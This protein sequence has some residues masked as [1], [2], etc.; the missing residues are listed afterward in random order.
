[1]VNTVSMAGLMA[2][3]NTIPYTASK[4]A[5]LALTESLHGE[6]R[7]IG[8]PVGVSALIPS[9]VR[10]NIIDNSPLGESDAASVARTRER[11]VGGMDPARVAEIVLA[12][13]AGDELWIHTSPE[14][15]DEVIRARMTALL[16]RTPA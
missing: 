8:A 10:T 9:A 3:P 14:I 11:L 16:T 6:L 12:G 7:A 15:A 4:H 5:V 1:M 13:I 2:A